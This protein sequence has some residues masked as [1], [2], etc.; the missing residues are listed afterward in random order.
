MV[1]TFTAAAAE[2]HK[3]AVLAVHEEVA[4]ARSAALALPAI[5]D[6]RELLGRLYDELTSGSV[7]GEQRRLSEVLLAV[8]PATDTPSSPD[9][10]TAHVDSAPSAIAP[11]DLDERIVWAFQRGIQGRFDPADVRTVGVTLSTGRART[12]FA[13]G[14]AQGMFEGAR[15]TLRD[16]VESMGQLLQAAMNWTLEAYATVYDVDLVAKLVRVWV[17]APGSP[18]GQRAILSVA[19]YYRENRPAGYQ[20]LIALSEAVPALEAFAQWLK[21]PGAGAKLLAAMTEDLGTAIGD[22][23]TR[24]RAHVADPGRLGEALGMTL[25][26]V[27]MEIALLVMGF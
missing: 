27:A 10:E 6:G 23:W 15:R 18:A 5:P 13:A 20:A 9:R 25:G 12:A 11:Y 22:E 14:V 16:A 21:K 24:I 4:G 8:K 19:D 26:V 17:R 2:S 7:G 1:R 3:S